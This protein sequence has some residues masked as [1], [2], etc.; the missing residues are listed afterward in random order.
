[1]KKRIIKLTEQDLE[2][3]VKKIIKEEEMDPNAPEEGGEEG[4]EEDGEED[5]NRLVTAFFDKLSKTKQV[6]VFF[7]KIAKR[8][9]PKPKAE[10]IV[11]FAEMVGVPKGKIASI[12]SDIRDAS[13]Q[14]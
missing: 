5:G 2:K 11:K 12:V 1:M 3:L 6:M 13:K 4:G 7:D 10:A 9:N 14:Q 8:N